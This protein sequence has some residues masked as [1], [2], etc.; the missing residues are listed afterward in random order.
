MPHYTTTLSQ[1]TIESLTLYTHLGAHEMRSAAKLLVLSTTERYFSSTF[2]GKGG[3]G[4]A[5]LRLA[6]RSNV[7]N[8]T[9]ETGEQNNAVSCA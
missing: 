8:V 7:T 4:D 9:F 6:V 2:L 5:G 3:M 1:S